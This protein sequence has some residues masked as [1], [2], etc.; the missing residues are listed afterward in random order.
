MSAS[1]LFAAPLWLRAQA[2]FARARRAIGFCLG[3]AKSRAVRRRILGWLAPLESIVRKLLFAEAARQKLRV[4]R[5]RKAPVFA[6]GAP[7]A[8]AVKASFLI[9][10]PPDPRV[11]AAHLAP[12]IRALWGPSPAAPPP[13]VRAIVTRAQDDLA[14]RFDA[15]AHVLKHPLRHARRL[16]RLI[17][18]VRRRFP[19]I[20]LRY[21]M[22][23]ARRVYADRDDP[24]LS[25]EA[26]AAAIAAAPRF[27]DSS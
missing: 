8:C 19:E 27:A 1:A 7:C 10:P 15:L 16:A 11:P 17:A 6:K 13:R 12:R 22:A 21:A 14:K 24:R 23:P 18:R 3:D 4:R 25:I 20:P 9:A 5:A 26:I 2:A